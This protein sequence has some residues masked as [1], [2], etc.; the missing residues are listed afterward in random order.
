MRAP[1][2]AALMLLLFQRAVSGPPRLSVLFLVVDDLRPD[3]GP[4]VQQQGS[5]G[6]GSRSLVATPA[7]DAFAKTAL[8][9]E[10]AYVQYS[11]CSP[12]RNS[13][14]SGRRP[15]TS[16][17]W[18][19]G[20][21]FREGA[22]ARWLSLP[23]FFKASH[24]LTVGTGKLFHPGWPPRNDEPLSWTPGYEYL[25]PECNPVGPGTQ[26]TDGGENGAYTCIVQVPN[27]S[28]SPPGC[29]GSSLCAANTSKDESRYDLQLE[30]QRITDRCI[31]LL[32]NA[33]APSTRSRFP[34]FFVGC[35]LHKP[36][37]PW[38][39]Q[40]SVS[41]VPPAPDAAAWSF[42]GG[43]ARVLRQASSCP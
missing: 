4:Y 6:G 11:Y 18:N 32:H 7:I 9:F 24:Y 34:Q 29:F 14:M 16:R 2:P 39:N 42:A 22:G 21:S 33:S 41:F 43:A 5:G 40:E 20:D 3:L 13:F 19:F 31:E 25:C 26:R 28:Y 30:D 8:T 10:R 12:S 15:D 37:T 23:Q 35:G 1:A 36:H 38:V 27:C 17:V